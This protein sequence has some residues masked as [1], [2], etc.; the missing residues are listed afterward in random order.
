MHI[1]EDKKIPKHNVVLGPEQNLY[2][3][4]DKEKLCRWTIECVLCLCCIIIHGLQM[5]ILMIDSLAQDRQSIT[6]FS[7]LLQLHFRR[8][9]NHVII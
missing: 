7:L 3:Q 6:I 5:H 2:R 9:I 1:A 4:I 8:W